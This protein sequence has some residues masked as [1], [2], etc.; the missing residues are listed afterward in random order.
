V[1]TPAEL[2]RYV[3]GFGACGECRY[4]QSGYAVL[5]FAC[6]RRTL[7]ILASRQKHCTTCD[8][9]F[10][11]DESFCR[12]PLCHHVDRQCHRHYAIAMR[13]GQLQRAIDRY[14]VHDR[15]GWALIFGRVLAGFLEQEAPTF[16]RFDLIVA[17]P[18]YV[19]PGSRGFDH[20]RLVL[21][22]AAAEVT[23][24]WPWPFDV[25]GQPTI[26]KTAPNRL[27]RGKT[28]QERWAIACDEIRSALSV[29]DPDR[30]AGRSILVYDDVFTDGITLNEVARALRTQG[31]AAEVCGVTLCR[32]PWQ[33]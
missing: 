25:G 5:C 18:A 26:V 11:Q 14:K 30:T 22:H 1:P 28:W 8:L 31:Q 2:L 23:P 15:W 24:G 6:A 21:E 13:S 4:A 20:I 12:N 33:D 32:Q 7:E 29:P 16:R 9:L 3:P 19:G 10:R 17:S 27:L